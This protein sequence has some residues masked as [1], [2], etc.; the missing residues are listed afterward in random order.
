MRQAGMPGWELPIWLEG[1]PRVILVDA[2]QMGLPPGTRRR[3][4][5]DE[6]RLIATSDI[7]SSHEPD[8]ATGL[9]LAQAL[10]LLPEELLIFG[11]EPESCEPGT[12]L[13]SNAEQALDGLIA[14]ILDEV[15]N[16]AERIRFTTA[17]AESEEIVNN[18]TPCSLRAPW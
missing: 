9:A 15:N 18:L 11:V 17:Y 3:F 16:P 5:P 4:S 8:L 6:V 7:L 10:D 1:W 12:P 14:D 13:S 2:V